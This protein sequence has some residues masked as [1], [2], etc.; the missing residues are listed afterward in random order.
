MEINHPHEGKSTVS[1]R[2]FRSQDRFFIGHTGRIGGGL[3]GS[4]ISAI[5][6]LTGKPRGA[7]AI[8]GT[9]EKL[10]FLTEIEPAE[11]F[12][13]RLGQFVHGMCARRERLKAE[14]EQTLASAI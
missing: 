6:R 10:A 5:E 3:K 8:G 7:I 1:G 2:F 12:V 4:D 11:V 13:T 14:S 9:L